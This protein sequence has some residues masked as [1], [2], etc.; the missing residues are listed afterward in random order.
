MSQTWRAWGR[1]VAD[2]ALTAVI[3]FALAT[4]ALDHVL[5]L[6]ARADL[7]RVASGISRLSVEFDSPRDL[8]SESAVGATSIRVEAGVLAAELPS[9]SANFRLNLRGQTL[10]AKRYPELLARVHL[11]HAADLILIFDE[12]H[13]LDENAARIALHAGWNEIQLELD[14]QTW[15]P[16]RA[17]ADLEWDYALCTAF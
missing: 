15:R 17:P 7:Y 5:V 10:I 16:V 3:L 1:I 6:Q 12:P 13:R 11:R 9:G 14:A 2:A 8:I 4:I